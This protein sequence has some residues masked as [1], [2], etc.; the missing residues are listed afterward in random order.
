VLDTNVLISALLFPISTPATV[1]QYC[2]DG[3]VDWI[4]TQPLLNEMNAVLGRERILKRIDRAVVDADAFR[5][6]ISINAHLVDPRRRIHAT[7][8]PADDAL[9]EAAVAGDA[10]Y[11]VTGDR[12]LLVLGSFEGVQI[13][14]PAQFVAL[15]ESA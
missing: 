5:R 7:R 9:L 10:Q 2:I 8:D 11:I 12:D 15:L 3:Q 13:V 1:V 6:D 4:T 14:T